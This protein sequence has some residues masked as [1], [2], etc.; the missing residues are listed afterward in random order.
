VAAAVAPRP[1]RRR[2]IALVVAAAIACAVGLGALGA[3]RERRTESTAARAVAEAGVRG[4]AIPVDARGPEAYIALGE[5]YLR[6]DRPA[7]A[8][9][10]FERYLALA[11]H[12]ERAREAREAVARLK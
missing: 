2:R 4:A 11:P 8:R 12:G 7:D 1:R 10:A 3:A 5:L 6:E 9:R